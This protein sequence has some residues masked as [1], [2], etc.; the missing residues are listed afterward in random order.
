[1]KG[2]DYEYPRY[3]FSN[4]SR[5]IKKL[6][7]DVCDQLGIEWRPWGKHHI[8]VAR[9]ESVALMDEFIGPKW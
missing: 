3:Q 7:T 4:R 5:D 6:F 1:V 2:K 9:R 8:S